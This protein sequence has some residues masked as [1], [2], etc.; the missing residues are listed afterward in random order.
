MRWSKAKAQ[1]LTEKLIREPIDGLTDA[2][3]QSR[4][5]RLGRIMDDTD[6]PQAY[7]FVRDAWSETRVALMRGKV[8]I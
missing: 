7:A 8:A 5:E 1:A 2:E 6:G 4:F 3:L